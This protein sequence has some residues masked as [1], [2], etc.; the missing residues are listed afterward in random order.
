MSVYINPIANGI[1]VSLLIIYLAFIPLFIHE[2]RKY[3]TLRMR[4]NIV[5]ASF[6]FYMITAWF[7]T[8]LPLPSFES[9]NNMAPIQPNFRPFLFVNTF[10]INNPGFDLIKPRT[11]LNVLCSASFF[12]VA[13]N[14]VLTIPFGVYLRKYF[15]LSLPLVSLM[16]FL[17]SLFYEITQY[18]GIYGI[19]SQAYRYPDVDDIMTNTLGAIMGYFLAN[20]IG[21]ILPNPDKDYEIIT[22]R[23]GLFRR[24]LALLVDII[25][26]D[27]I[28]YVS[29]EVLGLVVARKGWDLVIFLISEAIVF[30]FIPL[31]T[32]KKQTIGMLALRVSLTG[33]DGQSI[34]TS[35]VI[36][37][38]LFVGMWLHFIHGM[39][40]LLPFYPIEILFQLLFIIWLLVMIVK[41]IRLR[42]ICYFWEP[43]LDTYLKAYNS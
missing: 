21:G 15:K 38:N 24:L 39:E 25:L 9:V 19:Y 4:G 6:I 5:I 33:K 42:K 8:I 13:F 26:A 41:S 40:G 22:E 29:K 28:F 3:G 12:T 18:T 20:F 23:A 34:Q 2:Y 27:S 14:V 7:M 37:H 16:G 32:K 31:V 1:L 35:K 43:W 36:L 30:L 11:W 10:I 17:L